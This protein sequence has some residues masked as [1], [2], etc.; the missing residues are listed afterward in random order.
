[1]GHGKLARGEADVLYGIIY[2]GGLELHDP[3][4]L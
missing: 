2:L 4:K 1:M 3:I